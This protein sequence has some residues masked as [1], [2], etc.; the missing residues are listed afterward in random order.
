MSFFLVFDSK[1]GNLCNKA[2][3]SNNKYQNH[4]INFF[5]L[6]GYYKW[7]EGDLVPQRDKWIMEQGGGLCP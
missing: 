4:Q 3:T 6:Y 7:D 2:N 5:M 1:G